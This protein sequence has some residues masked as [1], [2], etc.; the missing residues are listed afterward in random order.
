[1]RTWQSDVGLTLLPGDRVE[2][3]VADLALARALYAGIPAAR[4]LARMRLASDERDL[5]ASQGTKA[6]SSTWD[7]MMAHLLGPTSAPAEKVRKAVARQTRAASDEGALRVS[8]SCA[9]ALAFAVAVSTDPD[10]SPAEIVGE[11]PRGDASELGLA[12]V[13][14][15]FEPRLASPHADRRAILFE[16]CIRLTTRAAAGP[17][18]AERLADAMDELAASELALTLLRPSSVALYPLAW[19]DEVAAVDRRMALLERAQLD[20]VVAKD[21]RELA[22]AIARS[23]RERRAHLHLDRL[24]ADLVT[25]LQPAGD[26]ILSVPPPDLDIDEMTPVPSVRPSWVP[27]SWSSPD[28]IAALADAVERGATTVPRLHGLVARAG[29]PALDAIGAEML[30]VASHPFAS[31]AF[32]EVLAASG[33]PRD[34]IRLVTFFAIAPDPTSAA[35]ALASCGAV[36]LPSVLR[37][38]LEAMLPSDG[39]PAPHGENPDTSS[40]A[41]L[42]ACVASLAPYP[43]L[44][45][46]VRPLLSRVSEAPPPNSSDGPGA[47]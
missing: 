19:G 35:R 47:V 37:A 43:R 39:A 44:Y 31:L 29:E 9:A 22:S 10:A 41:R 16:A 4:L 2:L 6:A 18:P 7:A 45:G 17:W 8:D 33:R 30:R 46:A 1:M 26:L 14:A 11:K 24:V 12:R 25:L 42:T 28:A 32:A 13:C 34:V 5:E 20:V 27:A 21:P 38:W 40:A 15:R 36:E 3:L 23:G